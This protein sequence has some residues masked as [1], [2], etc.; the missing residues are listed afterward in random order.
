MIAID[1]VSWSDALFLSINLLSRTIASLVI[2][3]ALLAGALNN[4]DT[5]RM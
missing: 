2:T 4:G 1:N 5:T 3:G